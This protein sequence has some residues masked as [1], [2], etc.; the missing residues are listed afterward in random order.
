M[1]YRDTVSLAGGV[2]AALAAGLAMWLL[3][4]TLQIRSIPERMLEWSLLFLPLDVF[5][6]GL[7]QFGFSAKRYALYVAILIMVALLSWLGVHA[8]RRGWSV[9]VLLATGIG[10]W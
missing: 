5:E 7:Q 1:T 9:P 3:R 10:L 4:G 6:T 8:L 2:G